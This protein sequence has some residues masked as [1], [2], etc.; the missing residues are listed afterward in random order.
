MKQS[1]QFYLR[2]PDKLFVCH[3]IQELGD[4]KIIPVW[5]TT[6]IDDM[7]LTRITGI[8]TE[9]EKALLQVDIDLIKYKNNGFEESY[10]KL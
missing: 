8:F 7:G 2:A 6:Y 3:E 4:R 10:I 5:V 1:E 9:K